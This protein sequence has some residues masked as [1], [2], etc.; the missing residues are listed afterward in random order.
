MTFAVFGYLD[1]AVAVK[2]S[3]E[4]DALSIDVLVANMSVLHGQAPALH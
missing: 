2:N 3:K 4:T 1:T